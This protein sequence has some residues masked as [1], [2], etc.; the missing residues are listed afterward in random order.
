MITTADKLTAPYDEAINY[1]LSGIGVLQMFPDQQMRCYQLFQ[2]L[3]IG[4]CKT[5]LRESNSDECQKRRI[6]ECQ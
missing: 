3:R 2:M 5:T 4:E 6:G 1:H